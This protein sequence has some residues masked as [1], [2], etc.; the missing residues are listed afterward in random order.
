MIVVIESQIAQFANTFAVESLLRKPWKY[1]RTRMSECLIKYF[2]TIGG[3]HGTEIG[4]TAKS[5]LLSSV[6]DG[7]NA[8]R[9][10]RS[11]SLVR[12][13]DHVFVVKASQ[14]ANLQHL[15]TGPPHVPELLHVDS[16]KTVS[17][18]DRKETYLGYLQF[19]GTRRYFPSL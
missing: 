10:F 14:W 9:R 2:V 6:Q 1:D 17:F 3:S 19:S 8:Q 12:W 5:K 15:V 11:S 16:V 4:A 18:A 7:R 13:V